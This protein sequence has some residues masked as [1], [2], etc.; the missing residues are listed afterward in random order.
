MKNPTLSNCY[1]LIY[2]IAKSS[3]LKPY[4]NFGQAQDINANGDIYYPALWVEPIES[5]FI[6]SSQGVKVTQIGFNLYMQD[7]IN[8]GDSNYLYS[9]NDMMYLL[10]TIPASIR[11]SSVARSLGISV[12]KVDQTVYPIQRE[13]D[14]NVNGY[15]IK[16]LLRCIN[17]VTPCNS[18]FG[19]EDPCNNCVEEYYE[20][21][22]LD[23][24]FNNINQLWEHIVYEKCN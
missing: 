10:S 3:D 14:E 23:I 6:N 8:K 5:K 18:P 13:T 24:K 2:D 11:E 19:V 9:L 12:D 1:Q 20:W 7:I 17:T 15:K 22:Q 21:V 4:V 16:L